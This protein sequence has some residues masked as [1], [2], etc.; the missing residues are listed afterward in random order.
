MSRNL[1]PK[2]CIVFRS[3]KERTEDYPKC[4]EVDPLKYREVSRLVDDVPSVR[5]EVSIPS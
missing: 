5:E 3:M 2:V 4:V 1:V